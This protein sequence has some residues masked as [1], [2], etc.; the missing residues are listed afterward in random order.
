LPYVTA[1]TKIRLLTSKKLNLL[2]PAVEIFIQQ[3][4]ALIEVRSTSDL[5]DRY[6]FIDKNSCYMSGA[7]FKDGAKNAPVAVIQVLDVMAENLS[8]YE[9]I[10][11]NSNIEK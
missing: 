3:D 5:H 10:W 8:K 6:I 4:G 1:G 2:L 11:N 9:N 7:S